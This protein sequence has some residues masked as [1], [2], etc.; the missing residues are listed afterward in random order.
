MKVC[1]ITT[2]HK[3]LDGRIFYKEA[4]SLSKIYDVLVI[5]A[6][7]EAGERQVESVKIVTIKRPRLRKLFHFITIWRIFKKGLELDCNIYHC[8]EPD[9]LIICL[10][11]KFIKRN[12]VKVIYDVHEH[13]PSEIRYGW[14][15]VKN[16]KILTTIIEK[17][18]WN[19]EH[20]AVNFADH[21]IVVNNHLAREFHMLSFKVSVIP[22]VPLI[23]ILKRSYSGDI[24]KKDAD[25][26]LMASKVANHYGINEILRSLYK[27]K[28]VYPKIKL[29]IIGDIKIDIKTTLD[30]FNMTDNV[31]LKGFLPLENMYYEI[32][33]GK[34][35]LNIV[36]PEFYN[37]YIGL[38][39]KLFDYM[40]CK[41]PVVASN[42]PEIKLII[43]QTKGGIL[44][45]P[46]NINEITKAIKYLIENPKDA[47]KMGIRNRKVIEKNINW[48]RSEKKLIRIYK[49][50]EEGK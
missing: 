40:A 12:N 2:V 31:I 33:K 20:K 9:S 25:L 5:A 7:R 30:R 14:L 13:W 35:G 8:H 1:M 47:K 19:I 37:I 49:L 28:K 34:I 46:E 4:R 32:E 27:L 41:L 22:N 48:K 29:K 21:I 38:S 50:L 44:V 36:K 42:L 17:L 15:R 10:L 3:P 45:D 26:I 18:I 23:T 43:K 11:I 39:T 24:N 16:N 6:N